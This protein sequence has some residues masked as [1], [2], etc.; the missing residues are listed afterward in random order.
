MI[1]VLQANGS[2]HTWVVCGHNE[3]DEISMTGS[4][5]VLE[6]REGEITEWDLDPS[7][8]GFALAKEGE[9]IGGS[10]EN[11]AR[12]ALSIFSGEETGPKRDMVIINAA[13]GLVVGGQAVDLEEG[14]K[15]AK[16]SIEAGGSLR[17]LEAIST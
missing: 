3:V 6:L 8:Y 16:Q 11:N 4:T 7:D 12:I 17:K 9:L 5:R 10:P 13:A 1:K 2:K 15:L 14:I